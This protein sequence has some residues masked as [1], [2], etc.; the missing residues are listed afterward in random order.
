MI[1][2]DVHNPFGRAAVP[3]LGDAACAS[4]AIENRMR[5]LHDPLRIGSDQ[6]VRS[7]LTGDRAFRVGAHGEE[8][9]SQYGAFLLDASAVGED[10]AGLR[11]Q[12]E[13]GQIAHGGHGSYAGVHFEAIQPGRRAG[14]DGEDYRNTVRDG[15][16][17]PEDE[18]QTVR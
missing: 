8:G 4:V 11:D 14:V 2:E 10:H 7:D 9:Y 3:L 17:C 15:I 16:D 6:H 1:E 12:A 13:E 18:C 5:F